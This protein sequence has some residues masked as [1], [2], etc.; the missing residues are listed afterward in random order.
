MAEV[1][2]NIERKKTTK[3][4]ILIASLCFFDLITT[5]IGLRLGAIEINVI[6]S[7]VGIATFL[8]IKSIITIVLLTI[9]V[10]RNNK[11]RKVEAKSKIILM[12][13]I[14]PNW[15]I[16]IVVFLSIVV[17]NNIITILRIA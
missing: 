16:I 2:T 13:E 14:N 5:I 4:T 1:T 12:N 3:L 8:L 17:F 9:I 7:L 11:K 6:S 10:I 15:L